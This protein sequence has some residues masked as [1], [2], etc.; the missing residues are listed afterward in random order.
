MLLPARKVPVAPAILKRREKQNNANFLWKDD[1]SS[2]APDLRE[3][4]YRQP[5]RFRRDSIAQ[6]KYNY[7]G[8]FEWPREV[9]N[10][11]GIDDADDDGA[12]DEK[13]HPTSRTV[14]LLEVKIIS[15]IVLYVP[16]QGPASK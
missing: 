16:G 15:G 4:L 6:L 11:F 1:E 8:S 3:A 7:A 13:E 9:G 2:P 14:R 5:G 10:D 12:D